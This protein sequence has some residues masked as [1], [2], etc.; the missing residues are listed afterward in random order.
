[1]YR[2]RKKNNTN[3][4]KTAKALWKHFLCK[5]YDRV[6]V[7][8]FPSWLSPS[9]SP[10]PISDFSFFSL[11][12]NWI[13]TRVDFLA[14]AARKL[15][16]TFLNYLLSMQRLFLNSYVVACVI[17]FMWLQVFEKYNLLHLSWDKKISLI[18]FCM[19]WC[20][21]F[22]LLFLFFVFVLLRF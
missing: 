10:S 15:P 21:L 20:M 11:L 6:A 16:K 18:F 9:P 17:V 14:L 22:L 2:V 3:F 8:C 13:F 7:P 12:R 1:M 4:S 19:C 5:L